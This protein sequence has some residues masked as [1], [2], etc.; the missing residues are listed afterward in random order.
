MHPAE[1]GHVVDDI[2][3]ALAEAR[4]KGRLL[5]ALGLDP[6]VPAIIADAVRAGRGICP[7]TCRWG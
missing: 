2:P 1:G 6:R 7:Q 5:P 4:F 3:A